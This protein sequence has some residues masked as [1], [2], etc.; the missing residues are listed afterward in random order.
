MTGGLFRALGEL[1]GLDRLVDEE[2]AQIVSLTEEDVLVPPERQEESLRMIF[3]YLEQQEA[4]ETAERAAAASEPAP[5]ESPGA[6]PPPL[7]PEAPRPEP[8][9]G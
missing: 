8:E 9:P 6:G 1:S 5:A 2:Q 4:E 3:S 7:E